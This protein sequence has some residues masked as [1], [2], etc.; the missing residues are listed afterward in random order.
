M[1][2]AYTCERQRHDNSS[3]SITKKWQEKRR[4]QRVQRQVAG[5]SRCPMCTLEVLS[6]VIAVFEVELFHRGMY[7]AML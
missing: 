2:L 5:T 1:R 7:R 6:V 4:Y 3:G